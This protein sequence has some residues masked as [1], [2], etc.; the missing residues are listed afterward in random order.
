MFILTRS[1]GLAQAGRALAIGLATLV[2]ACAAPQRGPAP[3]P[4]PPVQPAEPDAP[5][6]LPQAAQNK[7]ALLVPLTGPNAPVGR[8]I[9]NA[10][11]MALTDLGDTNIN[12]RVY[13]TATGAEGAAARALGEGAGVILGPLLARD[14]RVVS[15]RARARQVPVIAFSNDVSVAGDNVWI[16]GFQPEQAI[17]RVVRYAR[18]RGVERFAALVPAG[19][20]G[21][22]AQLAFVRAVAAAGGQATAV[23]TYTREPASQ[24]AAVRTV[25]AIDERSRARSATLPPVPFQALLI[26]DSGS[27]AVRFVPALSRFGAGPGETTL[28]GT[29]LWN[30]EPGLARNAGMNGALFATVPDGNFRT[31]QTRYRARYGST[32]SRLASLGYD[33]VLV[34][35]AIAGRWALDAPFPVRELTSRQGFS[36]VDG[37]FRFGGAHIAER[38]MEVEQIGEGRLRVVSPAPRGFSD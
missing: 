24:G 26:A 13:D 15:A 27:N 9:A 32:P 34:I 29:E 4:P 11:S 10:A 1:W 21:E 23:A 2:A 8:S 30:S 3:P 16:M 35:N 28:L 14:V 37:A 17:A 25:T 38:A 18:S 33:S 36:G 20:Y 5:P 19:V 7:V 22:R 12:L 6:P 31:L